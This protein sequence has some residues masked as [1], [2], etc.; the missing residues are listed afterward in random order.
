MM[1][2]LFLG[3]WLVRAIDEAAFGARGGSEVGG[4]GKGKGVV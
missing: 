2:T 3:S 4:R 1:V